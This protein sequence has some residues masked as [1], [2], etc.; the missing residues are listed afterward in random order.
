MSNAFKNV[1][2]YIAIVLFLFVVLLQL[3]RNGNT[4]KPIDLTALALSLIHI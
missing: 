3:A 1:F 4:P 2:F